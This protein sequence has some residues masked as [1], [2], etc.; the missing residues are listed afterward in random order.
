MSATSTSRRSVL[1]VLGLGAISTAIAP[2]VL[3]QACKEAAESSST[4]AYS[5]LS[6]AQAATVRAIQDHILP[7]TDTPSASELGSV[8]FLDTFITYGWKAED[9]QRL[10]YRLD[11]FTAALKADHQ[12]EL[13][14]ATPEHFDG[15]MQTYLVDYVAPERNESADIKIEG[16]LIE[17]E[18]RDM[19]THTQVEEAIQY[20]DDP[21]EINELLTGIRSLTLESYFQSEYIGEN[22]LNY[23]EVPEVFIGQYP[24]SEVPRGRSWSL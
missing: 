12:V 19:A 17:D 22:V 7:K 1:K 6:A 9:Q 15:M 23:D 10:L 8:A 18:S 11:K 21:T 14:D 4:Y 24:M 3:L 5:T 16:N 2:A 13:A 20:E